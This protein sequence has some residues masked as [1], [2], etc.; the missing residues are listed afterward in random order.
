MSTNEHTGGLYKTVAALSFSPMLILAICGMGLGFSRFRDVALLYLLVVS[1][2]AVTSQLT[3][4]Q[5][6]YRLPVDPYLIL[7]A[8]S[9]LAWVAGRLKVIPAEAP[10]LAGRGV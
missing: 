9:A 6:R 2:I 4:T 3:G 7:F 8:S 5:T 1:I 10:S